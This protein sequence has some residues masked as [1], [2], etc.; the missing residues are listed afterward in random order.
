MKNTITKA[1]RLRDFIKEELKHRIRSDC[2]LMETLELRYM[3]GWNF[4]C[5]AKKAE[6]LRKILHKMT[7]EWELEVHSRTPQGQSV[8]I[9]YKL[10]DK[11]HIKEV[12]NS[13]KAYVKKIVYKITEDDIAGMVK[14][15]EKLRWKAKASLVQKFCNMFGK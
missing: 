7:R 13:K 4:S 5:K 3:Q 6:S 1:P 2:E 14:D 10:C 15:K 9:F 12:S 11:V 8:E